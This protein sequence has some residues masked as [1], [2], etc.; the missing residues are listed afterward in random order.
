M[1][2]GH[3]RR[4]KCLS[5]VGA[6]SLAKVLKSHNPD[7]IGAGDHWESAVC[8]MPEV[9]VYQLPDSDVSFYRLGCRDHYILY[10]HIRQ[11]SLE[12]C[13]PHTRY[14]G[15]LQ[16]PCNQKEPDPIEQ[17]ASKNPNDPQDRK[18][19]SNK[20]TCATGRDSAFY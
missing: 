20:L 15:C 1:Q 16:K 19:E 6:R 7:D 3:N 13:G 12:L 17:V 10:R 2:R 11:L 18:E 8:K 4:Y 14:G 9:V 5:P